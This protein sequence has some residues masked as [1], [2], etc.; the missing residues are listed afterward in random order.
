MVRPEFPLIVTN[1]NFKSAIPDMVATKG[2]LQALDPSSVAVGELFLV[3]G[4]IGA[5]KDTHPPIATTL[6]REGSDYSAAIFG[7]LLDAEEVVLWKDVDGIYDSDP[8]KNEDAM[9]LG[10][11]AADYMKTLIA[12]GAQVVHPEVLG[13]V[14]TYKVPV[15]VKNFWNPEVPGTQ[16]VPQ[17]KIY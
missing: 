7:S 9:L 17:Q 15:R 16:I 8:K 12:K 3:E 14:R 4:F 2:K 13:M 5:V 6:G 11:V 1:N 10:S